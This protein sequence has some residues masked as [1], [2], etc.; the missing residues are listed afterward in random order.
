MR[1]SVIGCGHLGAPHAAAMAEL[2]HD[3][4]GVE[5]NPEAVK[6]LNAG[7][8]A[9]YEQD[10]DELLSR[11][12]G[13]GRLR[14]TTSLAEAA[15]FAEVHFIAVGTPLREDGQGYDV[16]QV[17][18]AVRTLAPMLTRPATVIGKST[19]TV[20]T[21]ARL[22]RILNENAAPGVEL[23]WNPEFLR[24]GKA[25]HDS[26]YPDRIVAGLTSPVAEKQVRAV[27]APII[28]RGVPLIVTDLPTAEVLKSAA[29]AFLA[30]KISFINA[31][32]EL[33][34][35]TG[36]DVTHIAHA[37]GID[38]RIGHAGMRPGIGFGGG[39]LP[40][41]VAAFTHRAQELGAHHAAGLLEAVQDVN[42]SRLEAAVRL[43]AS[44]LDTPVDG[45]RI[46]VLGAAFKAGTSD[47]RSSPAL[48]LAG[49]LHQAGA[50]VSIFDPQA[51]SAAR[52]MH[53]EYT[54]ADSL[55]DAVTGAEAVVIG[56][57]WDVFVRDDALPARL[58]GCVARPVVVDV[59][60]ALDTT[61]WQAAGWTVHQLGRP[62]HHPHI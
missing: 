53:P 32:A 48:K 18:A 57:E 20:G 14:F 41:D 29:N 59:R 5:L 21:A 9:F 31:M 17:L 40:K 43:V 11:H 50:H 34:D 15:D 7:R 22:Q 44:A 52:N 61:V 13:T 6:T 54:Y 62:T 8:G 36:A 37:I 55:T 3:V 24:E 25:V 35:A 30:T 2:G 10:L 60:T 27:Y 47:V 38:P 12:T 16:S 26:L 58:A 46:A 23:V 42:A 4:I 33:A 19:V 28:D 45:A 49:R 56:T 51:L 39:C 1:V